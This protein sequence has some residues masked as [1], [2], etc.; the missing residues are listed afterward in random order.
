MA[1][2]LGAALGVVTWLSNIT[3]EAQMLGQDRGWWTLRTFV[4]RVVNSGVIWAGLA[5]LAGWIVRRPAHGALAGVTVSIVAL[6]VHYGLGSAS[7][8]M[9]GA[10]WAS[11]SSWFIAAVVLCAPL[12]VVGVLARRVDVW[13]LLARLVVPAGAICEPFL[14]G[15]FNPR[16]TADQ[17][18][19]LASAAA[20]SVLLVGGLA[21]LVLVL[22]GWRGGGPRSLY[23]M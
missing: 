6:V 16:F 21:G 8:T 3:T 10:I 14:L 7:G 20:G 22:W 4:S 19:R 12:G 2:A 17:A 11:N 23:G 18:D 13:G 9:H 15:R 5:A 1:L